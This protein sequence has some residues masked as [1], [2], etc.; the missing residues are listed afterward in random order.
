MA[1]DYY[2]TIAAGAEAVLKVKGSRFLA[3][4]APAADKEAAE[5]F[6]AGLRKRWFDATHHCYAWSL[7]SGAAQLSRASDDGEPAG[8]AGKPILAVLQGRELTQLIVVVVR[9]FGGTKLGTGGLVRA[10]TDSATLVL[11][12]CRVE[13]IWHTRS[14]DLLLGYDQLST[15]LKLGERHG[16]VIGESDYGERVRLRLVLRQG[17]VSAF[18]RAAVEMTH[19]Q[20]QI[21]EVG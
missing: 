8:T 11:D 21:V 6:L 12:Q 2:Q 15:I 4:A 7:G 20:I 1:E 10:Y 9:Y 5:L 14:L 17:E 3:Y 19:G 13:K 18:A 16:A